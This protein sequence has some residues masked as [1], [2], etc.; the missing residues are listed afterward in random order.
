MKLLYD[1]LF[2]HAL[3]A[4]TNKKHGEKADLK[5][6][7]LK[8]ANLRWADL[9]GVDLRGANL[10]FSSGI[11]FYCGGTS[12]VGDDRLFYQMVYHLTRQ[13]WSSLSAEN[14]AFLESIPD[15]IKNGFCNY[16]DDLTKI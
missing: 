12:I 2:F 8:E 11:P 7:N 13:N 5:E 4:E 9:G 15:E 6:A 14:I 10:D 1:V 16:R 3:W